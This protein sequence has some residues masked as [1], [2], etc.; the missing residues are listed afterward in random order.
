MQVS[1]FFPDFRNDPSLHLLSIC[2]NST[3]ALLQSLH[4]ESYQSTWLVSIAMIKHEQK[5][6]G[7]ETLMS[8]GGKLGEELNP[9]TWR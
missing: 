5:Q 1:H 7:E 2:S 8:H 6:L 4:H 9:G 3:S